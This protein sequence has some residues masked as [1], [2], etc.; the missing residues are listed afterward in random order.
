MSD[1]KYYY[2]TF[3]NFIESG[4]TRCAGWLFDKTYS[5]NNRASSRVKKL[6]KMSLLELSREFNITLK[7]AKTLQYKIFKLKNKCF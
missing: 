5:T 3:Y 1:G 2:T 6:Q 4:N 7:Q